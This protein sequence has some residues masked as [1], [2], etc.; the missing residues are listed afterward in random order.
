MTFV[1]S[2]GFFV[3]ALTLA[4]TSAFAVLPLGGDNESGLEF[5][6]SLSQCQWYSPDPTVAITV[7]HARIIRVPYQGDTCAV[8][9]E[10]GAINAKYMALL[11]KT[12]NRAADRG[13]P[14]IL[15]L[16]KFGFLYG[17][18]P[19]HDIT[20]PQGE[21]DF[22]DIHHKV[23]TWLKANETPAEFGLIIDGLMN[24]PHTQ[25]DATLQ[26]LF[27]AA[28]NQD[29]ADGFMGPI[30]YP[31]TGYSG[32]H[33]LSVNSTFM[34]GVTDP[35]HNLLAEVH[36]Y[37]DPDYSG[38]HDVPIADGTLGR[39]TLAGAEAWSARTGILLLLDETGDPQ[40]IGA[41]K[42]V[43]TSFPA[44]A[45]QQSNAFFQ[46]FM[47]EAGGSGRYFA[48]LPWGGGQ[49]WGGY[50]FNDYPKNGA[51]TATGQT[52]ATLSFQLGQ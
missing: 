24:E 40:P 8:P 44:G 21:R 35:A 5:P 50:M 38:T 27:Q 17:T 20:T 51:W 45:W 11:A 41:D 3:A 25:S 32:A 23:I 1:K 2:V 18:D 4:S 29:R 31:A 47:D 52:Y 16:H 30:A 46:Q 34:A 33:N 13:V 28:I 12:I 6:K 49:Y 15:D 39:R 14:V 26:P 43:P 36:Q 9:V 42:S 48:I 10:G 37:F 19:A 22:L 7:G